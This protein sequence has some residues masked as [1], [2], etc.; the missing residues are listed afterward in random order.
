MAARSSS[1]LWTAEDV[2]N[3]V[4][5]EDNLEDGDGETFF[6]GSDDEL[7]LYEEAVWGDSESDDS[8]S[9][10]GTEDKNRLVF[11]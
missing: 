8:A 10:M 2:M 9:E 11:V 1:S 4:C 5:D 3:M 7:D 6:P